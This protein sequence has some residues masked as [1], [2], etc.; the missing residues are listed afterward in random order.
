MQGLEMR[1]AYLQRAITYMP[2]E[3]FHS[4]GNISVSVQLSDSVST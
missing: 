4:R 3:Y 2:T 1:T